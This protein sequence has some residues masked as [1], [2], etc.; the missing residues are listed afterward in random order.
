MAGLEAGCGEIMKTVES[1][2][3]RSIDARLP[4]ASPAEIP[5]LLRPVSLQAWGELLLAVPPEYP[6]VKAFFP[7]MASDDI[8]DSWTGSHG[9]TLLAQSVAFIASLTDGFLQLTGHGLEEARVL[10]F[11]CGWGRLIRLLYKY[12]SYDNI[13][14]V[15]PWDQSVAL[16]RDHGVK[17]H[18]ALSD[19]VPSSL[20]FEF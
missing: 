14:A 18:L 9:M 3:L 5:G 6:N 2:I 7:S 1:D 13:Y 11:G 16:C 8:Q 20:P 4:A 10:D 17:A 15:D 19:Y 12:A